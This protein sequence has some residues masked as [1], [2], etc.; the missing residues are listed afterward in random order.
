M[1]SL[2]GWFDG[3][4]IIRVDKQ[5]V[6]PSTSSSS[7]SLS[8]PSSGVYLKEYLGWVQDAW[9]C[10]NWIRT[11]DT[12]LEG[13][14]SEEGREEDL[15]MGDLCKPRLPLPLPGVS[16]G[17]L[18][19]GS[20]CGPAPLRWLCLARIRAFTTGENGVGGR[21]A[22]ERATSTASTSSV[23]GSVSVAVSG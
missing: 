19:M 6:C 15:C 3:G 11:E 23:G 14:R 21:Y 12:T 1:G 2:G 16:G 5:L 10:P 9:P 8:S 13:E 7:H 22:S 17:S 20:T 4:F 18:G